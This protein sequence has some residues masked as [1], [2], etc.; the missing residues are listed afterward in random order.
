MLQKKNKKKVLVAMSG[1]VDSSLVAILLKEEGYHVSGVTMKLIG[2][3]HSFSA[4]ERNI[5]QNTIE[6]NIQFANSVAKS[7]N[8]PSVNIYSTVPS[9]WSIV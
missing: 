7:I 1:G 8:I 4:S 3:D 6:R 2:D 5:L 9:A